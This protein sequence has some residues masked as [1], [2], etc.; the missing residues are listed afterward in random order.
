MFLRRFL[1]LATLFA[2]AAEPAYSQ[3]WLQRYLR[4]RRAK[5]EAKKAAAEAEKMQDDQENPGEEIRRAEPVNPTDPTL[6]GG[7]PETTIA[8]DGTAVPVRRAEPVAPPSA[9]PAETVRRAEPI[10]RAEPAEIT[11]PPPLRVEP[12]PAPTPVVRTSPPPVPRTTPER[13]VTVKPDATPTP[14]PAASPAAT[15][16]GVIAAATPTPN[17]EMDPNVNVIRVA[18]SNKPVAA[19]ISQFEYAN[20]FYAKKEYNRATSEYERYLS[21]YPSGGDRQAAFFR[22]AESHRQLRNVNAARKSYEALLLGYND[23]EFVGPAAYRIAELCFDEANYPDALA[24][25]RK[26]SVRIKDPAI[27]LSARYN[28]A[29]CQEVLKSASEAIQSYED[30]L[31]VTDNNPFREASRLS[32]ARLL[33]SVGRRTDAIA[34]YDALIKE[35]TKPALKAES[36]VRQALLLQEA[37]KTDKA[38]AAFN[39]AIAMPDIGNWKE[40]AAIGLLR[41]AYEGKNYQQVLDTFRATGADFS[42][43]A[44]PEVLLIAANSNRQLG[45]DNAARPLY[46]Q[47]IRDYPGSNYAKDAQY[48]RL[49]SLYN[50][51]A[52]ELLSEV[53]AYI[54]QNPEA[55]E[56]RDQL[57]LMKAEALYK[58][59][60][61]A[62][63]APLYASLDDSRLNSALKAE[64]LFKLGWCQTQAQPRNNDAIIDAYTAFLRQYPAHKLAPTALAQRAVSYQQKQNFKLALADFD[65]LLS[66]YPQATK[67]QELALE[68]KALILGQQNDNQGMAET[69]KALLRKFPSSAAAGKANF[70][71]GWAAGESR[72]YK[73]AIAPLE[74]A[75]K[76]DKEHYGERATRL[77]LQSHRI[78]ENRD[79][80]AKEVDIAEENKTKVPS[81]FLRW[82]GTEYFHAGDATHAEKY[83]TRLTAQAV[84]AELHAEDWLI[85]GSTRTKLGKWAD[86][87][88]ALQAYLG[89]VSEPS[90][91]ATGH[92]A[93]GEAQLGAKQFE[94]AKKSADAALTLQPEGRLNAQGRMLSGDIAMAQND[95]AAAAKFY[96]SVTLLFGDDSEL[97]PKALTQA[98]LAYRKAGDTA[99][100]AKVL[101]ELQSRYPESPV[102]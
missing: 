43:E 2:L 67:E 5:E 20:S 60:K 72:N 93:L 28:I 66:R 98:I 31:T 18:P 25:F 53:D 71:I 1:L 11:P 50:L 95:A 3:T 70:W 23:G 65:Q 54:A 22:L 90:Q 94:E 9:E 24:Y 15:A 52:P 17:D 55:G 57:T 27:A 78:T 64:A 77:L 75:R 42:A 100:A 101:N 85:L 63:A 62:A 19:D 45:K 10:R 32:L 79:A 36:T 92:L 46:E 21:L 58:T 99:Q 34:Q 89:K 91:Q 76:L 35:T 33:A 68:Q 96:Y 40:T 74:A 69:F 51:N 14:Q 44:Q 86:A 88:K 30:V 56:R 8:A 97:T 4:D 83:L 26:A 61:Y 47:I 39:R 12:T 29:R 59:R 37:G 7:V 16:G 102:P 87:E 13:I 49:V 82:L 41:A 48:Y 6:A 81:D 73:D 38:V 80:L 84:P